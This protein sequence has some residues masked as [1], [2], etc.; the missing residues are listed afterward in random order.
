MKLS[1]QFPACLFFF[2]FPKGFERKK[3]NKTLNNKDNIFYVR[4]NV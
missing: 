2:L 3:S 1:E 4:K